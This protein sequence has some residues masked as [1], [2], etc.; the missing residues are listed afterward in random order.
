MS[1]AT[2]LTESISPKIDEAAIKT[3]LVNAVWKKIN[4]DDKYTP[5]SAKK[6]W[7]WSQEVA[8]AIGMKQYDKFSMLDLDDKQLNALAKLLKVSV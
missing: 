8:T 2:N 5:A 6:T 4:K 1:R 7:A 3:K